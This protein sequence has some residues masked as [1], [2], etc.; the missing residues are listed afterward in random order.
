MKEKTNY[1]STCKRCNKKFV[2]YGEKEW[3]KVLTFKL[4][5]RHVAGFC[6]DC[7][8]KAKELGQV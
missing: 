1:E 7:I 8:N 6:D 4:I 2:N 5:L 3:D